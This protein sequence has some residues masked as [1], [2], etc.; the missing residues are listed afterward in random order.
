M[1]RNLNV[2]KEIK[3]IDYIKI[4]ADISQLSLENR[5]YV[6]GMAKGMLMQRQLMGARNGDNE[7][8]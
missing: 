6:A 2:N 1:N 7:E 3:K 5:I 4:I 8:S